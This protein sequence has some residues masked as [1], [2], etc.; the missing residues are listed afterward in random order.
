MKKLQGAH[1]RQ[2]GYEDEGAH[3]GAGA[4]L[5]AECRERPAP[6][7]GPGR[8]GEGAWTIARFWGSPG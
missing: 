4:H 8:V 5:K 2:V 1:H 6:C 3:T 7:P